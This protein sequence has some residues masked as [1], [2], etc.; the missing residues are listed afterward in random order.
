MAM[1]DINNVCYHYKTN[2]NKQILN[3]INM[4]FEEGKFY[5][6]VGVS[7][8]GKTTLL[9]LLAGLDEPQT[10]S[11]SYQGKNIQEEGLM[12]HRQQHVSLVFQNYNLIDYMTPYENLCLIKKKADPSI[13]LQLGLDED[14]IHRNVL[15]LSG[16]QQQRVALARSL[17]SDAPII[18]ADEPTGNLD[19]ETAED[20]IQ[21]L[22]ESAH[23]MNKCVIA[24]THSKQLAKEADTI[25]RI[26]RGMLYE[27]EC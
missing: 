27:F 24:V 11:I 1:L 2:K 19:G 23:K 7:G 5:V 21:I 14:D 3:D 6:I 20:I 9:S 13:L 17:I 10:G 26:K 16:G 25:L 12:K 8:S 15:H 4:S 22:K 18:L